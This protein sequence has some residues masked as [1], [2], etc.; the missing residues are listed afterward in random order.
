MLALQAAAGQHSAEL[1]RAE[2]ATLR[3]RLLKVAALV[4]RSVRRVLV[5]LP[6]SRGLSAVCSALLRKLGLPQSA[7]PPCAQPHRH[8]IGAA[9]QAG[10]FIDVIE[11][12]PDASKCYPPRSTRA[13]EAAPAWLFRTLRFPARHGRRLEA[14]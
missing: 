4:S 14:A 13:T 5:R 9:R 10:S 1:G 7:R 11:F 8:E 6:A 12:L 3:L 2:S